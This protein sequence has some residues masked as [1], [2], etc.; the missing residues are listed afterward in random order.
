M[1]QYNQQTKQLK[2]VPKSL[3]LLCGYKLI[4]TYSISWKLKTFY[5]LD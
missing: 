3:L 5:Y 4:P 1:T 2:S